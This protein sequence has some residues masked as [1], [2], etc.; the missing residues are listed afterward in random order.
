[1]K[2]LLK[3]YGHGLF[4]LYIFIYL[5]WFFY[6]EGRTDIVYNEIYCFI[7]DLIPFCQIF[8][9]P[10]LLWF[11]YIVSTCVFMF[12]KAERGEF[13]RFAIVLTGGMTFM[14]IFCT[15]YPNCVTLRPSE[16]TDAGILTSLIS[17]LYNIDTS[18]NVFPSVHVLNSI[19]ACVALEKNSF[20]KRFKFMR[21]INI[22]LCVSICLSTM[23]LKQHSI[24]DVI[25]AIALY[26]ILYVIIYIP[27]WKL[28][29]SKYI[30]LP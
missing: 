6:L 15:I 27:D 17:G 26:I 1:M 25:G 10:Y 24:I 3:K 12:F 11:L 4:A 9:I 20:F 29:K 21:F 16:I 2:E 13:L 23:F 18:T 5:P 30:V 19:V 8:I 22:T 7:D 28:F 14:L